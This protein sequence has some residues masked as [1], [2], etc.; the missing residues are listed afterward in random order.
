MLPSGT[1]ILIVDGDA[2]RGERL[3][4]ALDLPGAG[5]SIRRAGSL[6]EFREAA[7]ADPPD[8]ALAASAL[9]DGRLVE[10][11]TGPAED[12]P[13]PVLLLATPGEED[14]AAEVLRAGALDSV[15]ESPHALSDMPRSVARALREWKLL[16]E[17]E[18]LR[19]ELERREAKLRGIFSASPLGIGMVVHRVLREANGTLLRMTGYSREELIGQSARILYPS[20]EEFQYVGDEKYRQV[21]VSGPGTVECRWRRKDGGIIDILL[22][23]SV[24]DPDDMAKGV[25]FTALD[26]TARKRAESALR[27]SEANFRELTRQFH[28]ILDAFPDNITRQSGDLRVTW[29]NRSA[30]EATR[31]AR[32]ADT[33]GV[34][35]WDPVGKYCHS[36]WHGRS[37]PCEQCP[38]LQTFRT[39]EPAY[40]VV[41][42]SDGRVWELRTVPAIEDGGVKEVVEIGRDIT[43]SRR[44]E[45]QLRQARNMEAVGRLAGGIAH[46]FNNMLNVILGYSEI[47]MNR[48]EPGSPVVSS[49]EEITKAGRRSASL[50]EQ[51][52]AFSR[53]QIV[54][55]KIVRLDE[56][57]AE[58][59][60]MLRRMIGEDIRIEFR[61]GRDLWNIQIDPSQVTQ[62]LAN[63]AVNARDAIA[64]VGTITIETANATVDEAYRLRHRYARPGE[65]AMLAFSDTGAGMDEGTLRQIFEPF[66]TTKA[67]G[68]GTGLGLSTVYGIV[69]QNDGFINAYSEPGKGSVFRIYFPRV[70]ADAEKPVEVSRETL[71]RGTET[72]LLVEDERQI[73]SLATRILEIQGYRVLPSGSPVEACLLAERHVGKIHLLLT[74]VIMPGMNGRELQRRI[75]RSKTGIRT[76]FMSGY[77]EDAVVNRGIL[78]KGVSFVPKPFTV[79]QLA[80]KVRSVLDA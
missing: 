48:L 7:A 30:V 68:K 71:P 39:G 21:G 11:L 61:P 23:S 35:S 64:G 3:A 12:G 74:D 77:T 53:K 73:L 18:A 13:F 34:E 65:Y 10:A 55:P 45:E 8:I 33:A 72:I 69:K 2:A 37:S 70:P 15:A 43:E 76:L 32:A 38:T 44:M 57:V 80:E 14:A 46:D 54:S 51:L 29:A 79:R 75:E 4:R 27:Q 52:L 36:L 6:R 41:S 1:R 19:A 56:A 60:N 42:S 59:L 78:D 28:F 31:A 25:T 62:V 58:Q 66:F 9:P 67:L 5:I 16:Q 47:A 24:L 26:I 22:A 40:G 49:L 63:L 20:E 50:V 17:R